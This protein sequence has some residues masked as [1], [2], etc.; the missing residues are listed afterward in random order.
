MT[1]TAPSKLRSRLIR[2]RIVAMFFG[3]FGIAAYLRFSGWRPAGSKN[4][5][6]LLQPPKDL[7]A[8]ALHRADGRPYAWA[9]ADERWQVVVVAPA[10]CGAPCAR[11][12]DTL[13][14]VWLSEGRQA[15]RV[16]VL[17]F[18]ELPAQAPAF[19]GLVPMAANPAFVAALPDASRPEAL[20]VYFVDPGGFLVM[21]YA[22]GFDPSGMRK[23]LARLLK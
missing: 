20:P 6:E 9:P 12:L 17:W 19:S 10:D 15:A 1:D 13:H 8:I 14:R 23:D 21:R 18:G 16:Q 4:F 5:G 22:P 11:L 7:G 3:S 2:L